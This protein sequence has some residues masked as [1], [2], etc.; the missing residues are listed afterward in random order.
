MDLKE[1]FEKR[2]PWFT[3]FVIDGVKYGGEYDAAGDHRLTLFSDCFPQARTI[4]ELGAL[5]GGHSFGL[6]QLPNVE[7]VTAVE[8][9]PQNIE[10][11]K[12]VQ[13]VLGIANVEFVEL[14]LERAE[15]DKLGE[16]DVVFCSGLLYHLPE[17]WKLV[18]QI[19]S[20]SPNLF[21]STHIS[22]EEEGTRINNG[23][24]GKYYREYGWCD[25]L[26]GASRESF[27]LT[28][29]SLLHLLGQN[30]YNRIEIVEN[31]LHP[32]GQTV[33]LAARKI[34]VAENRMPRLE[35]T[36]FDISS[37]SDRLRRAWNADGVLGIVK[38]IVK[39]ALRPG[40]S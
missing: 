18:E 28:L 31:W 40:R 27:W 20:V 16:I 10:H 14:N 2:N 24:R 33:T 19:A 15:L 1:E 3:Q 35:G 36:Q 26:S 4:L 39:K 12:F 6:A 22:G 23:Y 34:E 11:A 8:V 37:R 25:P 29:G 32:R 38:R 7:K 17:P 21:L 13:G 30:G 9:R 5:E